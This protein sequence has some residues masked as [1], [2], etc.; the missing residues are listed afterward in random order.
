[1]PD[2]LASFDEKLEPSYGLQ[3][4]LLIQQEWFGGSFAFEKSSRFMGRH[5]WVK[6]MRLYNRGQQSVDD[7]KKVAARQDTDD[8]YQNLDWTPI[9]V[10]EKYT[11]I[12]SNGISDEYYNLD[13]R[14]TDRFAQTAKA[15]RMM[16]HRKNM[17]AKP[18]LEKAKALLGV[19][20]PSPGFVPEDEDE[21][22][23][24]SNIKE[25]P[26][27]EIAEE[28][29]VNFIK[30]TNDWDYIKKTVDNDSVVSGIMV[31]RVFTDPVNGVQI[32][33][34][35]PE[36]YGHSY[37]EKNN[38]SDAHYHFYI[39]TLTLN[40]L[41]RESGF[42]EVELR[43]IAKMYSGFNGANPM[44]DYSK[45]PMESLLNYR[46][47]VMRFA[48]KTDKEVVY[49]KYLDKRNRLHKVAKRGADFQVPEGAEDRRLATSMDTWM[50]GNYVIGSDEYVYDY[51]ESE[52]IARDEMD[53]AMSPFVVQ[54]YSIYKNELRSFLSNIVPMANQMQQI[55]LKIQ[56]LTAELK[57]DIIELDIDSLAE[58]VPDAKGT[59][60]AANWK[61]ALSILNVKGVVLKQRVNMGEDGIKESASARPM[62]NQQGSALAPLLNIWAHYYNLIRE[63]TGIN[64]AR[65]GSLSPDALVGVNQMMQLASNTATKHIVDASLAWDKRLCETIST[66]VKA[67]F[68][69]KEAEH[70]QKKYV[71][72]VGRHNVEAV[73]SMKNRH[74]HD[75][76]YTIQMVPAKEELDELKQDLAISLQEGSI[77]VS[78]KAE[79]QRLAKS[80]MKQAQEYMR[81]IRKRKI[82]EKLKQDQYNM[83]MQ[84][85]SNQE[86]AQAA[87]QAEVQGYQTKKG[88]DLQARAQEIAMELEK[89]QAIKQLNQPYQE[90]EYEHEVFLER[91]RQHATLKN[92]EE[93]EKAKDKRLNTQS[94]HQSKLI[95]QRKKE[96]MGAQD[97]TQATDF[98]GLI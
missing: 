62:G 97:F 39:D 4:A 29:L 85:K 25:R 13:V 18:I 10:V 43:K 1:M 81:Y 17:M 53:K 26:K 93:K 5:N 60:K 95:E 92:D 8:E 94:T 90:R 21:M 36:A 82:K 14:S 40:D 52:N 46:I 38:F 6:E 35:D 47:H 24:Y 20:M 49:K 11:N 28:I 51:R 87:A 54:S 71:Q 41:R 76:G 9:N 37:V 98:E 42:G 72:A 56:H 55:H 2:P 32:E 63:T 68:A 45:I 70:I 88:V 31:A 86:A 27:Q 59:G 3:A 50:E 91:L 12:V 67:I 19:E 77:D 73:K 7:I 80:N 61:T 15:E 66:R 65:D 22:E 84:S 75:F 44:S 89:E 83:E 74:L 69:H 78:E 48:F 58:L 57:P 34:V 64:P 96:A 16:E 33:Y 79:I 30:E 23:L